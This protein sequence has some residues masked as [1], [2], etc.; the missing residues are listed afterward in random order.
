MS[1]LYNQTLQQNACFDPK[2]IVTP[3][4]IPTPEPSRSKSPSPLTIESRPVPPVSTSLGTTQSITL[5]GLILVVGLFRFAPGVAG[6]LTKKWKKRM[7]G[8]YGEGGEGDGECSGC[9]HSYDILV[10]LS[11]TGEAVVENVR[12]EDILFFSDIHYKQ[13]QQLVSSET[14]RGHV[15]VRDRDTV[16]MMNNTGH[17]L[18]V[19]LQVYFSDRY[20]CLSAGDAGCAK[21]HGEEEGIN[22][23]TVNGD[24]RS[25]NRSSA[26]SRGHVVDG[27]IVSGSKKLKKGGGEVRR[28]VSSAVVFKNPHADDRRGEGEGDGGASVSVESIPMADAAIYQGT[29]IFASAAVPSKSLL[30][31]LE[32]RAANPRRVKHIA[33]ESAFC[34]GSDAGRHHRPTH[35]GHRDLSCSRSPSQ[36]PSRSG[37]DSNPPARRPRSKQLRREKEIGRNKGEEKKGRKVVP[38]SAASG[39]HEEGSQAVDGSRYYRDDAIGQGQGQSRRCVNKIQYLDSR[40]AS[41]E[42]VSI[43]IAALT[44]NRNPNRDR[45]RDSRLSHDLPFVG[46][47]VQRIVRKER[48]RGMKGRSGLVVLPSNRNRSSDVY[49]SRH[50]F[51]SD[52]SSG[53]SDAHANADDDVQNEDQ[54]EGEYQ[55]AMRKQRER[56]KEGGQQQRGERMR[57]GRERA[58][59]REKRRQRRNSALDNFTTMSSLTNRFSTSES[60]DSSHSSLTSSPSSSSSSS[61]SSRETSAVNND[62]C[63]PDHNVGTIAFRE[64]ER[65]AY[66]FTSLL[67]IYLFTIILHLSLV[68][69]F[70]SLPFLSML[71]VAVISQ[72]G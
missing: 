10:V 59:N 41:G 18:A 28:V 14:S 43:D 70:L 51:G 27:E 31:S 46:P 26:L 22:I 15:G 33:V 2:T 37:G 8:V 30:F 52:V 57:G 19:G 60:I 7:K 58:E 67:F 32:D 40:G 55:R 49:D 69:L 4:V 9:V 54:N 72:P 35:I 3:E 68:L 63:S 21:G 5:L 6:I 17:L 47:V 44:L 12:H 53:G 38:Y 48:D 25:R 61:G 50:G 65:R 1:Y 11:D 66:I 24:G 64:G 34:N 45:H 36:S 16:W 42:L 13:K 39:V 56:E 20:G 62:A 23:F 29:I 71:L